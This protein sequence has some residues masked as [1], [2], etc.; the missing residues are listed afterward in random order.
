MVA[1]GTLEMGLAKLGSLNLKLGGR[2]EDDG[3]G[4]TRSG[5]VRISVE[6]VEVWYQCFKGLEHVEWSNNSLM[7]FVS[8]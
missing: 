8:F 1:R 4:G 2:V 7:R 6:A 5:S 3:T